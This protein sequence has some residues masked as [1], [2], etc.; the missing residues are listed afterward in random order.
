MKIICRILILLGLIH[1]MACTNVVMTSASAMYNRHGL[2]KNI[3]DQYITMQAFK[4]LKIKT[5]DFKN[6]NVSVATLNNEVLLAGQVPEAWQKEKAEEIVRKIPGIENVYNQI[7]I[8]SP[9]SSLTRLSDSWITAKIKAKILASDDID[10]TQLKVVTENG[11]VFLMGAL[12]PKEADAAVEI[13]RTTGGVESV[14]RVLS[15]IKISKDR[16]AV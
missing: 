7:Q 6:A 11:T 5:D 9:S 13:A 2:Q 14:V 8:G 16:M 4:S 15:Y 1:V 10:S 3:H 12:L